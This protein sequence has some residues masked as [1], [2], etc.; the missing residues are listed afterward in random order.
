MDIII[1]IAYHRF[2]S[3][4]HYFYTTT[5]TMNISREYEEAM[6]RL[7]I[8]ERTVIK[9]VIEKIRYDEYWGDCFNELEKRRDLM[10]KKEEIKKKEAERK[11][12]KNRAIG[13][14]CVGTVAY[15]CAVLITR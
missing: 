9:N 8:Y 2:H 1:K 11:L 12:A 10:K 13:I 15:S 7:P 4:S 14:L 5:Q 3:L 6:N